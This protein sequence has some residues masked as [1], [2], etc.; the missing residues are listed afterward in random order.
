MPKFTVCI[1]AYNRAALLRPL[2][3]SVSSQAFD[4]VE[5]LVCEDGSPERDAIRAVV[6]AFARTGG[7]PV[8]YHE[9]ERNLGYDGNLRRLVELAAGDYCL[10]MGNDDLVAPGALRT[11]GEL[12][13]RHPDVGVV[14]RSYA[15]FRDDPAQS[16]QTFRYFADERFFPHGV[17]SVVTAFRRCVVISGLVLRREDALRAA[18]DQFD[19]T[20][21]YQL[22]LAARILTRA[23]AVYTPAVIALYR[24]GGVP[25][26]GNAESERGRFVPKDQTAASS[27]AFMEGMLRIAKQVE[28]LEQLPVYDAIRA[29]LS[30]YSYPFLSIQAHRSAREFFR[31][32]RDL[33]ALG[34]AVS[35][36]FAIYF[37]GLLV[38]GPARMD[39]AI[40]WLKQRLGR[41]PALG[42]LYQGERA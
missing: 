21:L 2:L 39:A 34:L 37:A 32:S 6:E 20:L 38:L 22:Y 18:T 23:N 4:S 30:R 8:R 3:D 19:G 36:L 35:P 13:D 24:L 5:I 7:T 28:M 27:V 17:N 14:I 15:T 9:N 1:P 41:A 10:F 40:A 33:A 29:D 26:F 16:E 42:N 31:Y 12:V 25:D 11:L